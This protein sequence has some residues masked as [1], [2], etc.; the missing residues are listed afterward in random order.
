MSYAGRKCINP[1]YIRIS[2]ERKKDVVIPIPSMRKDIDEYMDNLLIG[3]DIDAYA[4][5]AQ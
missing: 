5:R 3:K 1:Q 4:K 2:I